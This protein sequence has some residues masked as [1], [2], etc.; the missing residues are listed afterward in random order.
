MGNYVGE[1][2]GKIHCKYRT[3]AEC[4]KALGW[5]RQRLNAITTGKRLPSVV[6]LNDLA[7]V[8]GVAFDDMANI[9]LSRM[10]TN[11]QQSA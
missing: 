5:T 4:A 9:F 1:L 8:L 2:R 10:S 3:E 7:I 6:E 11:A